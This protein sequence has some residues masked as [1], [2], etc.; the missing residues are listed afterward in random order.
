MQTDE[1]INLLAADVGPVAR[2]APAQRLA[3]GAGAGAIVVFL[4]VLGWLGLRPDL[5]KA[6]GGAFF[7]IKTAYTAAL[8]AAGFWAV[9]RLGRPGVS[10]SRPAGFGAAVLLLFVLAAMA[11]GVGMSG[12]ARLVALEGVSWTVCTRNIAILAAPLLAITLL[13]LR[14]LAPTRPT[15]AGF[16]AGAFS[17]GLA[18]TLYGLH[19]PEATFVFVALWYTLGVAVSAGF[20]AAV[21]RWALRW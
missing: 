17:G 4:L 12:S 9:E 8:G 16:A 15:V 14:Q 18:A 20:G 10:A 21:G 1:L 19:C 11:Q 7:W 6:V 5:A 13:M 2:S 3:L